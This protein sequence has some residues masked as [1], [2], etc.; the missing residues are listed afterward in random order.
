M[1]V[2]H[3]QDR[4]KQA[5]AP[6]PAPPMSEADKFHALIAQHEDEKAKKA[7][8][9]GCGIEEGLAKTESG[10]RRKL[11]CKRGRQARNDRPPRRSAA[12]WLLQI[13][14]DPAASQRKW[15]SPNGF[16]TTPGLEAMELVQFWMST[17]RFATRTFKSGMSQVRPSTTGR[18]PEQ[19]AGRA[20]ANLESPHSTTPLSKDPHKG[21][22]PSPWR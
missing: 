17:T 19:S 22:V 5:F 8:P 21:V 2:M 16:G 4:Q 6:P 20:A 11:T 3:D 13:T 15:S 14:F 10:G 18:G 7:D 1:K 9:E 12:D